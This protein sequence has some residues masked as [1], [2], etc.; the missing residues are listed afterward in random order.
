MASQSVNKYFLTMCQALLYIMLS[1][2]GAYNPLLWW[3]EETSNLWT[4][5]L[6]PYRITAFFWGPLT[7]VLTRKKLNTNVLLQV[8]KAI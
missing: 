4:M 6:F 8:S 5:Y 2:I 3:T 7:S 1:K